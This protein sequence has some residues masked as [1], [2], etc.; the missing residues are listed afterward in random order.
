MSLMAHYRSTLFLL[1]GVT[2]LTSTLSPVQ[3]AQNSSDLGMANS[4]T[5]QMQTHTQLVQLAPDIKLKARNGE[6]TPDPRFIPQTPIVAETAL[7]A[8]PQKPAPK[9][10]TTAP[11]TS[12]IPQPIRN[13][14]HSLGRHRGLL[15]LGLAAVLV[16]GGAVSI[17]IR[18]LSDDELETARPKPGTSPK[19]PPLTAHVPNSTVRVDPETISQPAPHQLHPSTS[20]NFSGS[21]GRGTTTAYPMPEAMSDPTDEPGESGWRDT[22]TTGNTNYPEQYSNGSSD[23]P[24]AD[25]SS[26]EASTSDSTDLLT[27][28]NSLGLPRTQILEELLQELHNPNPAK[29]RK[30]I[31]ELG[32]RGDARAI[33]PLVN[34]LADSDSKQHSLILA[35]L[36]EIG[37]RILKPLN[38]AWSLSLQDEKAEVR[39]NA[40]RDLTRLYELL[41]QISPLLQRATDDPD[42][43]VQETAR[44]ALGQF[45]GFGISD[46]G[47]GANS[48]ETRNSFEFDSRMGKGDDW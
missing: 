48:N 25:R 45:K 19:Q 3:A 26:L 24:L 6:L 44:W 27:V 12:K 41:A 28:E 8:T 36:S 9:K 38:R 33:E 40:I 1:T 35:T 30:A 10:P 21:D 47:R 43:E 22:F 2:C 13:A 15:L 4:T 31:W 37:V 17:L 16:T 42:T 20:P 46:R 23:E 11:S 7:A 39:K 34:L 5:V 18:L 32:Q 14:L 29:R